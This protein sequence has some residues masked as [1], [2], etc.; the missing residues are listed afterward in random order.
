MFN[1]FLR[2]KCFSGRVMY[3]LFY[4]DKLLFYENIFIL[5]LFF[6][7]QAQEVHV[8]Q[9]STSVMT[10][11]VPDKEV[12]VMAVQSAEMGQM[13]FLNIVVVQV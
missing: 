11:H 2:P 13:S 4:F 10:G 6:S 12:A 1:N 5:N 3:D 8:V 9:V 7:L